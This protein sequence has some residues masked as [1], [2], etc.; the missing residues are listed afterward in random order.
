MNY[1]VR[2]WDLQQLGQCGYE[3]RFEIILVFD[4]A[5]I[6]LELYQKRFIEYR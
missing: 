6:G 2:L 3:T 5:T 1:D 4:G